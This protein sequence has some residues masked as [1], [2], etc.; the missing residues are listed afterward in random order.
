MTA[1]GRDREVPILDAQTSSCCARSVH[2]RGGSLRRELC[3]TWECVG[4]VLGVLRGWYGLWG[5]LRG[6]GDGRWR[7][8]EEYM[9]LMVFPLVFGYVVCLF[10]GSCCSLSV[11]QLLTTII[12]VTVC[13]SYSTPPPSPLCSSSLCSFRRLSNSRSRLTRRKH[14][15]ARTD[16]FCHP[17]HRFLVPAVIVTAVLAYRLTKTGSLSKN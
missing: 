1:L 11:I 10:L 16:I 17:D 15:H 4:C 5:G 12:L 13:T 14:C 6:G 8:L 9:I 7:R 2:C 3:G